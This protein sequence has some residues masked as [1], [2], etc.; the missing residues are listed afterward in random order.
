MECPASHALLEPGVNL[1]AVQRVWRAEGLSLR[2]RKRR[3]IRVEPAN[4]VT[5]SRFGDAWS[6]DFAW[7]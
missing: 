6:V 1:K 4:R 3:R 5:P 7:V 2:T